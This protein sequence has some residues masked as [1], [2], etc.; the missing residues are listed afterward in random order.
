[1]KRPEAFPSDGLR[2]Y[3]RWKDDSGPRPTGLDGVLFEVQIKT[4]LE[5]AWAIAT[6][7]LIYK[8]ERMDWGKARIAYQIK[9][10]LEHAETSIVGADALARSEA[11]PKENAHFKEVGK[12]IALLDELW[13]PESLPRDKR[14]L[15]ENVQGLAGG[16]DIGIDELGDILRSETRDGRGAALLNLSPYGVVVQSVMNHAEAKIAKFLACR[17]AKTRLFITPEL[18]VPPSID[19]QRSQ[20]VVLATEP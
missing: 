13:P 1:M 15:A 14:R 11:L 16:L 18:E 17:M 9:A 7:D 8:A 10:M 19:L 6:H 3:V 2:L 5:H 4:F 20:N 12:T